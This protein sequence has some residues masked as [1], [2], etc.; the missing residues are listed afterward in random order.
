LLKKYLS[1]Y[2]TQSIR[3]SLK[4]FRFSET[5]TRH[6]KVNCGNAGKLLKA[7]KGIQY[8]GATSLNTITPS[9]KEKQPDFY[10]LFTDGNHNFGK[11]K[12]ESLR[13][14][15]QVY[16][17]IPA[18]GSNHKFLK[19]LAFETG[20]NAL[21]LGKKENRQISDIMGPSAY[22]FISATAGNNSVTELFPN[23][24]QPADKPLTVT[25]ILLKK[26]AIVTLNYGINGK[27]LKKVPYKL[28][29][30]RATKS[31]IIRTFWAQE[32]IR[33]LMKTPDSKKELIDT[34]KKYGMVTPG[35][36]LIV[37]E[38]LRQY[39]EFRIK[40]PESLPRMRADYE[41]RIAG[42]KKR[43]INKFEEI[44]KLWQKR[45][46]W[47]NKDFQAPKSKTK[48][49]KEMAVLRE[50]VRES[51]PETT[52]KP[53]ARPAQT[54]SKPE[55]TAAES[56]KTAAKPPVTVSSERSAEATR[57][58]L[59]NIFGNIVLA[60]G[61]VFPG[62][63]VELT[64]G[65]NKKSV[66]NEQGTFIFRMLKPGTYQL[67]AELDGFKTV[68]QKNISVASGSNSHLNVMMETASI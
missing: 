28:S 32:K 64:G 27:I 24:S 44:V 4:E 33:A 14:K 66:S 65:A 16:V 48:K 54:E 45:V 57:S 35:T 58:G 60:D 11:W 26:K 41:A 51:M 49:K 59:G 13:F 31:S 63:L 18:A 43:Q 38:S 56:R 25:G 47:W 42:K 36:S 1:Q 8:D 62:V 10:L 20:G 55:T 23:Y 34:G 40:P 52:Q 67:R 17:I 5:K 19:S 3:V 39:L 15:R 29:R 30:Q 50:P 6:F 68:I 37:L 7:I 61:N 12:K 22:R 53:T 9:A 46:Q 2:K 21:D